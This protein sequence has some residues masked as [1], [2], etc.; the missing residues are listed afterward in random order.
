[1]EF[2]T[3]SYYGEFQ[4]I[5]DKCTDNCCI[6]W[7]I[8]ID[9]DT[10]AYYRSLDGAFGKRLRENIAE[11]DTF[12]LQDERCPF[13]N[14]KNLCDLIINC[15]KEH[16]CQICRDHPRYFEWYGNVKE[17]GI[18]LS[19]EEG[20]RLVLTTDRVLLHES[21][22]DEQEDEIDEDLFH[23]LCTFRKQIF[24]LLDHDTL[25]LADK[26][27][28]ILSFTEKL[29]FMMDNPQAE[30]EDF[31]PCACAQTEISVADFADLFADFEPIDDLWTSEL[32]NM[33][34]QLPTVFSA[35]SAREEQYIINLCRYFLWRYFLKGTF[36]GEI[37][38][39]V[40]FA[41]A[42]PLVIRLL[43]GEERSF[44]A[45]QATA[46]L[47]S[48]QMEYSDENRELFYNYTYEK[49]CLATSQLQLLVKIL[50][51]R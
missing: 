40:K 17:G 33:Q 26:L 50:T 13:L 15:G 12:I 46:K 34:T 11:D 4:C 24:D 18:G 9:S 14:H 47:Y 28:T 5:A 3:P 27:C 51:E 48:K 2:I 6:G 38:S 42:S 23:F 44:A 39:K 19:C 7:E 22:T 25:S 10:A 29:Q 49:E 43:C 20:A 8:G 31:V 41:V 36:D 1:M 32:Q 37:L 30:Q 21:Q 35:L 45:W 16:L